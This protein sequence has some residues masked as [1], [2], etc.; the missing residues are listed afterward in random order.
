MA[1]RIFLRRM[2]I[3]LGM[4]F[5]VSL[6]SP[7]TPH[8]PSVWHNLTIITD[9]RKDYHVYQHTASWRWDISQP[10]VNNTG[11][12]VRKQIETGD[13]LFE[14]SFH[15]SA[16]CPA[17]LEHWSK[18]IEK[19]SSESPYGTFESDSLFHAP[20]HHLASCGCHWCPH[21]KCQHHLCGG[22]QMDTQ[23]GC[24]MMKI[25][26]YNVWNLNRLESEE[27]EDRLERLGQVLC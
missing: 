17:S 12:C 16:N 3:V 26:T 24:R 6:T 1:N 23:S 19:W 14:K 27:Y 25:A 11:S 22:I 18:S 9:H 10:V 20:L 7:E 15:Y 5:S 21:I 8:C 4:H 2:Y 13:R